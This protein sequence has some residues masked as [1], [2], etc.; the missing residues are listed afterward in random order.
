MK[1]SQMADQVVWISALAGLGMAVA[2]WFGARAHAEGVE[3]APYGFLRTSIVGAS[4]SVDSFGNANLSAPLSARPDSEAHG[5]EDRLS[6]QVAQSRIGT[7]IRKG[8]VAGQVEMDF[9]DFTKASPTTRTVPRLRIAKIDYK[10]GTGSTLTLGQ[11]WDVFS[12]GKPLTYNPVALY[13]HAGNA[14]FM[15]QQARYTVAMEGSTLSTAIGLT[16]QNPN[17]SDTEIERGG[18]PTIS[19]SQV[20][21]FDAQTEAG[22][23]EIAGRA[24]ATGENEFKPVYGVNAFLSRDVPDCKLRWEG[25]YGQNLGS[26]GALTLTS[27]NQF[28]SR[29]EWGTY[30]TA[31]HAFNPMWSGTLGVGY[32][33]VTESAGADADGI[34][35]YA[36]RNNLRL[37]GAVA[38]ELEKGFSLFGQVTRFSTAFT[39]VSNQQDETAQRFVIELGG[40]YQF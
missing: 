28:G 17:A 37:E 4:G 22:F 18:L 36:I 40:L 34:P 31:S 19:A 15:R 32:A 14:G 25:Y 2:S 29:H 20:R 24:R 26:I 39:R 27:A 8:S 11:D 5:G 21:R 38:V 10:F 12:P 30:A 35:G 13:F 16:A 7:W 33:A 9:I 6:F 1:R 23:S 3:F